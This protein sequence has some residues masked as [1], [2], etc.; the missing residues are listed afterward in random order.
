MRRRLAFAALVPTL[1]LL[2][3]AAAAHAGI[4]ALDAPVP[5]EGPVGAR[6]VATEA[7]KPRSFNFSDLPRRAPNENAP[8]TLRREHEWK[9][10]A[11]MVDK[12]KAN[13]PYLPVEQDRQ[14]T[15]DTTP[16]GQLKGSLSPLAP[17]LGTGFEGITQAGFIPSEPTVGGGPLNIFSAGNVSVTVTDKNGSNRVET[18]G[19]TFFG[20]PAAEGA[21]SDAQC[22][23]DALRGR[24]I[25]IAFTQGTSPTKFSNF[26]LVI[27]KTNDARGAWWQY[28]FDMT[29]DGSTST[30]NWGDYE[31]LGVSDDKIVFSSQQFSFSGN[32]YQYQ[33]LRVIDRAAAYS[34]AAL[35]YADLFNFAA[36]AG[37]D[38]ND[39][40]VTKPAR[41]LTAGDN[42]IYC[43]C[44]R[45]GGGS[46]VTFRTVTGPPSAPVLS[47][48]NLVACSAYSPPPDAVQMGTSNLVATNDCRPS[49]FY[50]RNGVL[51]MAWHTAASISSTNVSAIRLF[52]MRL[53]DHTVL[54]D[55]TFGQASTFYFYPAVT[56]DSVGTIFLGFGRSSSTEFPSAYASGKR[57][58]DATIEPSALIKAGIAGTTQSRWG[59][60]TGIDNDASQASP[61][62]SVAWYAGQ[63]NKSNTV[64]GTW[65]NKLSF[66]YGQ[67][68]GTVSD[69]CDGSAGTSGDRLPI[70]GVTVA[71]KQGATTIASTTT[72]ALGQYSFGYVE[73]GTFDVVATPPAGGTNVDAVAGTGGTTQTRISASDV[74]IVMTNAQSSSAN[75]F[76][77]AST[78]PLPAT[79]N[80]S[81]SVRS[82]GDPQ[83]TLTVNGSNFS[84]C[85]VVR[86]DGS[87]RATTFVNSG[88]LTA[89]ISATD[90]GAGGTKTITVFTPAPGGGT[91]NGQTL[92]INGTPDTT[93]PTVAI[94]SPVGGESWGAGTIHNITWTASD[95]VVVNTID[96]A[97]S[98]NGGATFP[99]SIATGLSNSG[100]FAWTLPV[101]LTNQARV[102]V[103]AHDGT[104]NIGSDSSHTNFSIT[105]W[106]MT[107]SAGANGSIS[108]TGSFAVADGA[109]PSFTITPN[110]GYHVLD[111]LVNGSSVGAVTNYQFPAVHANQT[112]AASFAINTYTLTLSTAGNGTVAAVP[113]QVTYN[114]GTSIQLTATPSAGWNFDFWSGDT[115]GSTNPLTFIITSN[116]NIT[117]NFGQHI[118]TWNQTGTASFATATNWTPSR[119]APAVND[120]L[121]F[122]NGAAAAIATGVTSQTIGQLLVSG[123]T[124]IA[125]QSAVASTVTIAGAGGSDLSV[126][127]GSTLQLS[128]T[129]A[130]MLAIG[131]GA[132][133]DIS[134]TAV[135][136]SAAHRI[137]AVDP[138]SL[139]FNSG[140]LCTAGVGFGG[141]PFGT[142]A[143][144][145]VEFKAGSIYQH[146]AGA[147]PFGATAPNSV[148]TFD[149]GSRYRLDGALAPSMSGRTYADFEYNNGGTQ[150][151]TGG[152]PLT[153]D[154]LIVTQGTLNLNM[155][156][157]VFI[158]GD[159]HVKTGATLGFS[160]ASGSP[161]FSFAGPA[162]Q[163]IDVQGSFSN[164]SNAITDV[165]NS[166]GVS[167]VTNLTLNGLVTFT[168]GGLNTGARTLTLSTTSNTSG[169]SQGTGWV[170][171]TLRKT[172]A[173]GA[174]S[175][176]LDV[177]DAATY[178][179]IDIAGSGATAGFNLTATSAAGDHG[180]IGSSTI[181]P[182][183]SVNRHWSLASASATGATWSA[184]FDF[185]SSDLD[186]T[187]DPL[188][189]IGRVWN[190]SA[191]STL[192]LG[193]LGA[194]G[195]QVTGLSASTPGTEFAF[196]NASSPNRTLV[197]TAIGVGSVTK[198]PDQ[199]SYTNGSTVQLTAVPGTGWAFSA[200]SGDLTGNT[201]PASL[202]M[203]ANKSVTATFADVQ[204]PTVTVTAPNGGEV[205]N[206]G[207]STS[208]TW[209]ATD[210]TH[211]KN[212]DLDL[213]R[214]GTG[215]PFESIAAGI[216]N[217]GSFSWNVTGPVS[218][219][220]FL[221]V[222]ARDSTSNTGQDLSNA[223]F[224]IAAVAGVF[225]GP[226]TE[227]AL[228][229]VLPNPVHGG[230]RFLFAMP[231]DAPIHLS[232]H[233]VQGRELLVLADGPFPAGRH[234]IDWTSSAHTRLGPG[235]YF[236]RLTVPGRSFVQR[237][238]LVR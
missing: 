150:S 159:V 60:Y 18:N 230:T 43:M 176:T 181:D 214:S 17:T 168:A 13:P 238:A 96:L 218:A 49:D 44:V 88:Q 161:V 127:A 112:I 3:L 7:V 204:G 108:P 38:V 6:R 47:T 87:D 66:T 121:V 227:F 9:E 58:A 143:L 77:V 105:G 14:F 184:T 50:T 135:L 19:A 26:Y 210:N 119:T 104:G 53:S 42:T 29:L 64:F 59:D 82:V 174:F 192:T 213:S 144:G 207:S 55:E 56:V 99:T 116:K 10:L 172:Y 81:P 179:P 72:N 73:S 209:T 177:G 84:T 76:V 23:Y 215:G 142:S 91:S 51:T 233:D 31:G 220:A 67:V 136:M 139:V 186:P 114:H 37:G 190:G 226:I 1:A 173:A 208:L 170:N 34:G 157:G 75:N 162:A 149:A 145:T 107:A 158:R 22:Y 39:N 169:A 118:Y 236:V 152:N 69:D 101:V 198:L 71:L 68:F 217:T 165:N 16:P 20:V 54:T 57:R 41:N 21:I 62:Q 102:R 70:A 156:G 124:N 191:W 28:K 155:T 188:T 134:G 111:V 222:T 183:R 120:V 33:K 89:T 212:V 201:N 223:A 8:I 86:I 146:I 123:N 129:N 151:P 46:R 85:S 40:F 12:L 203:D 216:A 171:G 206:V 125:L 128:G 100:T 95:N 166:A 36:P 5:P 4:E 63:W 160:P 103:L 141:S 15:L 106:T 130:V 167:L 65:I 140:A 199:V 25:A 196:G 193:T 194:N 163:S 133:G 202:L 147:N 229:P 80:I 154:S 93:P 2:V 92:T 178:A 90:Q 185:P 182:T 235:L 94:T 232:V 148:V 197:L 231:K 175:N 131:S 187:A 35:T 225:D 98:T 79:T 122:N 27:S 164:T 113:N 219:S 153:L 221:R 117:A 45:A 115:T 138:N 200:W 224:S 211:V 97:L 78:K 126:A 11:E 24:F 137:S 61:S 48:G 110:F 52:Q 237:F 32:Q 195:T 189:F 30:N 132:T 234:S 83:F 205:L 74:Q 228:A 109:T 180:N